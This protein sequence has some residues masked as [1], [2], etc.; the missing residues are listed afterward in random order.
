MSLPMQ[1]PAG[2]TL[3]L[4]QSGETGLYADQRCSFTM[5]IPGHP[6]LHAPSAGPSEPAYESLV[7][8]AELPVTLRFRLSSLAELLRRRPLPQRWSAPLP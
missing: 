5:G 1:L 4:D 8:L 2:I 3:T 7:V 6:A